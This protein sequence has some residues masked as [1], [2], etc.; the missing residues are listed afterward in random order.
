M[1][2]RRLL[3]TLLLGTLLACS[4]DAPTGALDATTPGEDAAGPADGAPEDIGAGPT[5]GPVTPGP[6]L[7][8]SDA[9]TSTA[10]DAGEVSD[11]GTSTAS[12]AGPAPDGGVDLDAGPAPDLGTPDSGLPDDL[13]DACNAGGD[14]ST[15]YCFDRIGTDVCS[16]CAVNGDCG[17]QQACRYDNGL[18]YAVCVG[19]GNLGASCTQDAQCASTHCTSGVC[20][21]CESEQDCTEGGTCVDDRSG[22]GYFI[23]TGGLGDACTTGTDCGTG[24]CYDPPGPGSNR[25]SEC[26]VNGDCGA[27]RSCRYSLGDQYASCVGTGS[28][29]NICNTDGQCAS[30]HCNGGVCSQCKTGQDCA[31]GGDCVDDTGGVGYFICAGGLGDVCTTGSDCNSGFC[32]SIPLRADRCSEC[33]TNQDC[34]NNRPC[35]LNLQGYA[36]CY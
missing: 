3:P 10:A 17:V 36:V 30:G 4:S 20:S 27:Q 32:Y 9:G 25:C 26:E 14:C 23:C 18:G 7:G 13:G 28:L 21:E 31:G 24:Y 11:A 19:T 35:A 16:L 34:P 15:G 22:V 6:D 33:E 5:D 8:L 1:N 29:G 12:D 2:L